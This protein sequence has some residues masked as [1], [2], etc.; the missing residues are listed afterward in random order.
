MCGIDQHA[1]SVHV[2]YDSSPERGQPDL[3]IA[4][5]APARPVGFVV[6]DEHRAHAQVVIG[7]N[8]VE[9]S[10]EGL[11][12]LEVEGDRQATRGLCSSHVWHGSDEHEPFFTLQH[13]T[14]KSR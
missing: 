10:V 13:A 6:G 3:G 5:T 12:A 4:M 11:G 8:H 9:A 7:L 2:L 1:G 14:P